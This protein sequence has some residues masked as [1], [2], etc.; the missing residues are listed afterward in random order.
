MLCCANYQLPLDIRLALEEYPRIRQCMVKF[1]SAEYLVLIDR[2][3]CDYFWIQLVDENV[4]FVD[5]R[6]LNDKRF[7]FVTGKNFVAEAPEKV[8]E[9]IVDMIYERPLEI[10]DYPLSK[11]VFPLQ[12][13]SLDVGQGVYP[14]PERVFAPYVDITAWPT[15][16][17]A[18]E[19]LITG[20]R[21]YNLGFIVASSATDCTPS[22]GTYY[23]IEAIPGLEQI[24][25]LR[26]L[27]GD[28]CA[29]FGGAANI[30]LHICA[31]DAVTLKNLYREVVD[32]YDFR[33]IDFDIEGAW[34]EYDEKNIMNAEALKMLQDE[35]NAL[36]RP[37]AISLT[38]P[39]LPT[40]L[41]PSGERI[42]GYMYEAGVDLACVNIMAMDYGPPIPDMGAAAIEAMVNLNDQ[43]GGDAWQTIGVT[44]MIG[45]NDIP[46]EVFTVENAEVVRAFCEA[47]NVAMISM[48]SS[49]RDNSMASGINQEDNEFAFTWVPYTSIAMPLFPAFKKT[50]ITRP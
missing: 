4:Y 22:W 19:A 47:E 34:T 18:D 24:K 17:I 35:L 9:Q 43:L 11:A 44:P 31:E 48:W 41:V 6:R 14:W 8:I 37:L 28:V 13:L 40:G 29:S 16:L 5:L 7:I 12:A 46:G 33:R 49:N 50:V 3:T 39:V 10:K 30:P 42:V 1:K 36:G 21:Y 25:Q 38:L 2:C 20:V 23:P 15:Y 26:E 27:G 32:L 45:E